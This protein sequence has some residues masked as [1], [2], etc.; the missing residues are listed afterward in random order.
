MRHHGVVYVG[1][2]K[3]SVRDANFSCKIHNDLTKQT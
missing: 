2:I 1:H 3:M